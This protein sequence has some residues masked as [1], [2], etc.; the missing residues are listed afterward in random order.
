MP[1]TRFNSRPTTREST[2]PQQCDIREIIPSRAA[3]SRANAAT[4]RQRN[5]GTPRKSVTRE[6]QPQTGLL[7]NLPGSVSSNSIA[8]VVN[9]TTTAHQRV[10]VISSTYPKH[11]A[12]DAVP[13]MREI[14]Q[15]MSERGHQI[16]VLA[17]AYKGLQSHKL[18]GIEVRRFRYA[19]ASFE[20]LTHEEGTAYKIRGRSMQLLAI[21]YIIFG[22]IAAAWLVLTRKFDVVHVHSPYPNGL[23]GQ[24]ARFF[25]GAPLVIMSHAADLQ[26]ARRKNWAGLLLKQSL[27][28]ADLLIADSSDTA[29]KVTKLSQRKCHIL[30]CG[31]KASAVNT[32]QP[33]NRVA[34]VLFSGQL[35]ECKGLE[36]LLRAVPR[37]LEKHPAQFIIAGNGDQRSK[38][39]KLS[40]TLGISKSVKFIG[41]VSDAQLGDEFANCDIW[42]NPAIVNSQGDAEGLSLGVIEAYNYLKP[43]VAANVGGNLDAVIDGVTGRLVPQ[44]DSVALADAICELLADPVKRQRMGRNGFYFAQKTFSRNRIVTDLESL[45]REVTCE[46]VPATTSL[47]PRKAFQSLHG[48]PCTFKRPGNTTHYKPIVSTTLS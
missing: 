22:C 35:N 6:Y 38:F 43:V 1:T 37:I 20:R 28:A 44:K 19:P 26:P 48:L 42:V 34:Q 33:Q 24:V 5:P 9:N 30:P 45:Y 21:P 13:W 2:K 15:Q 16:T 10:L 41:L 46:S 12:D 3:T 32:D 14:H 8:S 7:S 18:D 23:L 11:E 39:E 31:I 40:Q 27:R 4:E 29:R 47:D 17:P 25:S 36:Y